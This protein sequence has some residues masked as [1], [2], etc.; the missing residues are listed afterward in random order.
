MHMDST[1]TD[2]PAKEMLAD[3]GGWIHVSV[4]VCVLF[5]YVGHSCSKDSR[6]GVIEKVNY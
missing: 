5:L 4:A 6:E 2:R 1:E 3:M